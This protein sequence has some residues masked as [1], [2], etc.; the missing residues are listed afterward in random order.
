MTHKQEFVAV[1]EVA[2]IPICNFYILSSNLSGD[3]RFSRG[4]TN[5]WG[6]VLQCRLILSQRHK[7]AVRLAVLL[8]LG[9]IDPMRRGVYRQARA[10]IGRRN[11]RSHRPKGIRPVEEIAATV[12]R[13]RSSTLNRRLGTAGLPSEVSGLVKTSTSAP[14]AQSAGPPPRARTRTRRWK[15][16]TSG[17]YS[18]RDLRS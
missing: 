16:S 17:Q 11:V 6:Q 12:R 13:I 8:L 18:S 10:R 7:T 14:V 9:S 4:S 3:E 1:E 5:S 2:L 15:S